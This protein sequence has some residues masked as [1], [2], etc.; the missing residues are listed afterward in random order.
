MTERFYGPYGIVLR[1]VREG[2]RDGQ[3]RV[4]LLRFRRVRI[5]S[6]VRGMLLGDGE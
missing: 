1:L 2:P 5:R 6:C 3:E 4:L